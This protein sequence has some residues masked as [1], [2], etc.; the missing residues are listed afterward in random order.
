MVVGGFYI[1]PGLQGKSFCSLLL[2]FFYVGVGIVFSNYM[3]GA[4][5]PNV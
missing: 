5:V 3:S 2:F 1:F 4:S